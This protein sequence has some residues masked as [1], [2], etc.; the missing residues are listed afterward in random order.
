MQ[1]RVWTLQGKA[2][3]TAASRLSAQVEQLPGYKA[4]GAWAELGS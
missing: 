2:R 3:Y 1:T 4:C